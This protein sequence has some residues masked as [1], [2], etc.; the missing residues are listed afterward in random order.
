MEAQR[1]PDD[2]DGIV[3]GAPANQMQFSPGFADALVPPN[4]TI[5]YYNAVRETAG[6]Q[7]RTD[8][9]ARLFLING[10]NHC[11]GGPTPDTSDLILQMVRWVENDT[12]PEAITAGPLTVPKYDQVRPDDDV[13]WA[14]D[15]LSRPRGSRD[16]D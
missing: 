13:V 11:G 9:F 4:G 15:Y 5:D 3:V 16:D 8:R 10:M 12:A 1:F 14:G 6:G 7:R 2:F